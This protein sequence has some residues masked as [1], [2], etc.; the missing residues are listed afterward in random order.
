ML[1][2][3]DL[4]L[5][6]PESER[7]RTAFV[8]QVIFNHKSSEAYETAVIADQYARKRNATIMAYQKILHT[9]A[10]QTIP[11]MYGANYKL[12]SGFFKFITTQEVQFLLG[13]GCTWQDESTM[14]RLGKVARDN[15]N[16]VKSDFDTKLQK[17]GKIA[18]V[19]GEGF[20]FFNKDHLEVFG[21]TEFAPIYD[22]VNGALRAGVRFWQIDE[23]KPLRAVLYEEDGY[24]EYIYGERDRE[25]NVNNEGR[26]F[27]AKSPYI[28]KTKTSVADG[29]YIYDGLNYPTLPIVPMWGNPEHQSELVGLREQIDAYDLIKSGFCNTVDEASIV[30][31]IIQGAGGMDDFDLNQFLDRVRKVHAAAPQEGQTVEPQSIEPP[32]Q[33]RDTLLNRLEADIYRDAMAF[34]PKSIVSGSTVQAQIRASYEPLNEKVDEFEYCVLEFIDGLLE[35]VGIDDIPSFTRSMMVNVQEEV[36]TVLQA[37]AFLDDDYVTRKITTLLG[38]GDQAEDILARRDAED[39]DRLADDEEDLD[40]A[41][42]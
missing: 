24:T 14:E 18:V 28:A 17:L 6:D 36:Q 38:D 23:M 25:G 1:T 9:L 11:D 39:L 26:I 32:Y 15:R 34:D 7:D 22:E 29:T 5:V 10:G 27:K 12:R 20:G 33:S 2:Y 3:Q 13:N 37:A 31:W 16:N 8:R 40:E 30:Y 21:L 41:I 42:A 19:Q 35:V 4:I